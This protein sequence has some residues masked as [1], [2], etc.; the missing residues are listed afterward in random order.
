MTR[1]TVRGRVGRRVGSDNA[2]L[3]IADPEMCVGITTLTPIHPGL[4]QE[5]AETAEE[6]F[7]DDHDRLAFDVDSILASEQ[8]VARCLGHWQR[9]WEGLPN[10]RNV[11]LGEDSAN[12]IVG[13]F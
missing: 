4:P 10:H 2:G 1:S 9:S 12:W 5:P 3:V 6:P 11:T 7:S 13:P 8:H